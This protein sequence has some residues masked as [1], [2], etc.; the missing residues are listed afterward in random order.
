MAVKKG[1]GVEAAESVAGM[2]AVGREE[3]EGVPPALELA[4]GVPV[5]AVENVGGR[6]AE[7]ESEGVGDWEEEAEAEEDNEGVA[8]TE[9]VP[10]TE[11]LALTVGVEAAVLV[12][13]RVLEATGEVLGV[14]VMEGDTEAEEEG[15]ATMLPLRA[16][17]AVR[18]GVTEGDAGADSV[19]EAA[20]EAV[21]A[22]EEE[23]RGEPESCPVPVNQGEEEPV[24]LGEG[25]AE[26]LPDSV[27]KN[28]LVKRADSVDCWLGL[29]FSLPVPAAVAVGSALSEVTALAELSREAVLR[30]LKEGTGGN[31]PVDQGDRLALGDAAVESVWEADLLG[32]AVLLLLGD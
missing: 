16:L 14:V 1:V 26:G 30:G 20:A 25:D 10:Y 3:G 21:S 19:G 8:V 24:M 13:S 22:A 28:V 9:N 32:E 4:S 7:L 17:E 18:E 27:L 6:V 11:P 29:A 2:E 31:D 12:G 15:E 23:T 5:A